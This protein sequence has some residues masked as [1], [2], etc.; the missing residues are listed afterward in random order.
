MALTQ[1]DLQAIAE[2]MDRKL[3]AEREHTSRMMDEKLEPIKADV[4]KIDK[5]IPKVNG[6]YESIVG[7]GEKFNRLDLVESK[8]DDHDHRLFAVEEQ[9][10][11]A[12]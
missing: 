10:K 12:K 6:L 9:L 2:L 11:K 5:L 7:T 1:E 8:V 3:E 4:A